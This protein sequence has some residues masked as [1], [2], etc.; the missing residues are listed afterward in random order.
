MRALGIVNFKRIFAKFIFLLFL[1]FIFTFLIFFILILL[2]NNWNAVVQ[3][4]FLYQYDRIHA[5]LKSFVVFL[6]FRQNCANIQKNISNIFIISFF[7]LYNQSFLQKIQSNSIFSHALIK[8][9]IIII[10]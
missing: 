1:Y 5:C 8:T 3:N 4:F 6:Q 7:L 2:K 9:C 10:G